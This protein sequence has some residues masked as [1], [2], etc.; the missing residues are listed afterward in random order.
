M[1]LQRAAEVLHRRES[2][3]SWDGCPP[4]TDRARV[5]DQHGLLRHTGAPSLCHY[6]SATFEVMQW[7]SPEFGYAIEAWSDIEDEQAVYF[8]NRPGP[9]DQE[10]LDWGLLTAHTRSGKVVVAPWDYLVMEHR[11]DI[12]TNLRVVRPS[13]FRRNFRPGPST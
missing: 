2:G 3:S 12:R 8:E 10:G 9:F 11:D 1:S 6:A 5:L 4:C 7:T 13:E